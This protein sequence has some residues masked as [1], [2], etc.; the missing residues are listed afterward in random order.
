MSEVF[1]YCALV[2][3]LLIAFGGMFIL[4][5]AALTPPR[6]KALKMNAHFILVHVNPQTLRPTLVEMDPNVVP[7]L[8]FSGPYQNCAMVPDSPDIVHFPRTSS[9]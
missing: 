6:S 8:I 1:G 2:A 3:S 5:K 7:N 9:K 4:A